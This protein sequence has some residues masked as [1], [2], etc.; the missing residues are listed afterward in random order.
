MEIIDTF[1]NTEVLLRTYPLLLKGLWIT[2]KLGVVSIIAGL[3]WA[4]ALR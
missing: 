3:A 4:L 1:F 2:I